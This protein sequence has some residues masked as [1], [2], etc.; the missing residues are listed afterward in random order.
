[1]PTF[2]PHVIV[3]TGDLWTAA[4]HNLFIKGNWDFINEITGEYAMPHDGWQ[5]LTGAGAPGPTQYESTGGGVKPNWEAIRFVD[6]SLTSYDNAWVVPR[7]YGVSDFLE[8]WGYMT[9]ANVGAKTTRMGVWARSVGENDNIDTTVYTT[10]AATGVT[11]ENTAGVL[12][13]GSITVTATVTSTDQLLLRLFRDG[14][15]GNDDAL[16]EYR[17]I[18]SRYVFNFA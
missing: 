14:A 5:P 8:I 9:A 16:G 7:G 6:A 17:M 4:N 1:M 10:N 15:H 11:V 13:K 3:N 2:T 12:F 18:G